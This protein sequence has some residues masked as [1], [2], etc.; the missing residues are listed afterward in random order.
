MTQR[1]TKE[2]K[3]IRLPEQRIREI[4]ELVRSWPYETKAFMRARLNQYRPRFTSLNNLL[5]ALRSLFMQPKERKFVILKDPSILTDWQKRFELSGQTNPQEAWHKILE[6]E[7]SVGDYEYLLYLLEK[8]LADI[9]VP[10]ELKKLFNKIYR[11]H[12]RK[13]YISD[14]E[15]PKA[16]LLLFVGPSGAGKTATVTE[17]VEKVIFINEVQPEVDLQK[18][19][20]AL[21]A[22]EP[23]WKTLEMVD[24]DLV[25]EINRQKKLRFYKRLSKI[26]LVNSIFKK[27]I[28]TNLSDLEEQSL[29]VDYA[30]V[31]PNDYQTALAGEPGNYFKKAL[32]DP[33]KSAIRHVEEA[34]SAFG[35]ASGRESG[36]ERQ[37]R[38]L[39]DTSNI[40]IDEIIN[41]RRDCLLIAT[42]DQPERFDSAIYRRFVGKGKIID[43]SD[44]WMTADNLQEVVRMELL[45]S[46]IHVGT[47]DDPYCGIDGICLDPNETHVAVEK[48]YTIFKERSLKVIPSYVRKLINSII[49]IRGDFKPEYL[50]DAF[51]VRKAF[52]LVAKNSY[53]DLYKKVVDKMDRDVHW[54]DYVGSVKDVFSEM[55]NNCLYYGVSEEKGVVLNGPPGGGKTFL[56]RAWLSENS[57]IHDISTS[58]SA[59]QDPVNPVEGAVDNLEKVYDIAK[60][61]APTV[62]FFDEGDS[63]APKR[64]QT[65]GSPTDRLTNKFLNLIDGEIPLNQV[66]TVLTTNRLDILD[67]A[68]IRSKRL[69]VMEISG[70]MG[71][72]D[73][74]DIVRQAVADIPLASDVDVDTI[75]ESAK[76]ICNTPADYTAFVEKAMSLRNTEYEVLTRFRSQG[77]EQL[78]VR[79]NFFKFNFKTLIGI[80]EAIEAPKALITGIKKNPA[81][82]TDRYDEI[83]D[84]TSRV[85]SIENYP[86]VVSH[87]KSAVREISGSPVRKGKVQLDKFLEAE[88]SQ[89]PQV[90][91]I[92]G[93]GANDMAGVL[94][95]IATSLTYKLGDDRVLVT[96]AV[97]SSGSATA[98]MDMAVKMTQQSAQ[99]ALTMVKNYLQGLYPKV[100]MP[101]LLGEYLSQYTIHHQLL[102]ASYNVGGPSAGYALA[103]NT[104]SSILQLPVWHD[105]GITGAPWTKGVKKDEVGGS[106]IIGGHRK[107]TE[108]VLLHLRRMFMPL[109][110]YYDLEKEFIY[111]FWG[112]EKDILGVTHFGDLVPEIMWLDDECEAIQNDLIKTR[113]EY[114]RNKYMSNKTDPNMKQHILN[115]KETLREVVEAEIV[116]RLRSVHTYLTNPGRDQLLSVSEIFAKEDHGRFYEFRMAFGKIKEKIRAME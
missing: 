38:T 35:K 100:S 63:L 26:P 11:A 87:L 116:K 14:P 92:I 24:P 53:G 67:P 42:S 33:R 83:L 36:V 106:V 50:D 15:V 18:K 59:L 1:L 66:F 23:I 105:F 114:K 4:E 110:N 81:S 82:V 77:G 55:S 57:D 74:K 13:E 70:H 91:F 16:P 94:L 45:R 75:V 6:K 84:Q 9:H 49:Q 39:I 46:N 88:L 51:L 5:D 73:I 52:E 99:E 20:E 93:V 34:H 98:Q 65:G 62:I 109:Q 101:K 113:L 19:K 41:G 44:F 30:M 22:G 86:V 107:K 40:V 115:R 61:I 80:L 85:D 25:T 103:I 71:R 56:V 112:R 54:Q 95:P 96:G 58:P 89:E 111:G 60:M 108:Q 78:E 97:S 69:K 21:L 102:S 72:D 28:S 31:T 10:D 37:Q 47:E 17:T 104:L 2:I 12:I 90:G 48:L 79:E 8:E 32:G 64:S 3:Y 7:V 29:P 27:V 68:L 43:I 76:E